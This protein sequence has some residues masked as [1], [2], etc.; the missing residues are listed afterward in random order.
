MIASHTYGLGL[1]ILNACLFVQ[2]SMALTNVPVPE[3]EEISIISGKPST[4]L[5][6][7]PQFM[8]PHIKMPFAISHHSAF[9]QIHILLF[10]QTYMY[11]SLYFISED[12]FL[13]GNYVPCGTPYNFNSRITHTYSKLVRTECQITPAVLYTHMQG[14]QDLISQTCKLKSLLTP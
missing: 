6:S 1:P 4:Y 7:T 10:T 13:T 3:T 8:L 14:L 12:L 11:P 5:T 2:V 9:P